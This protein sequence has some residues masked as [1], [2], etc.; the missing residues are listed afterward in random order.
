MYQ[1]Y[2]RSYRDSD[3]DGTGDIIGITE[4]L[5]HLVDIG[6]GF[7]WLSPVLESP[8]KDFGY[9]ISNYTRYDA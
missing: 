4:R 3:S 8:M 1:I 7:V 6:V 9:D 2:P 5:D